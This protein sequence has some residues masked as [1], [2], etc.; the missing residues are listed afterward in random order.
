MGSACPY[1]YLWS[2]STGN[3]R[4]NRKICNIK[5][6]QSLGQAKNNAELL[7][8]DDFPRSAEDDFEFSPRKNFKFSYRVTA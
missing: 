8:A 3:N 5:N 1:L 2:Q 7:P 4:P 6:M